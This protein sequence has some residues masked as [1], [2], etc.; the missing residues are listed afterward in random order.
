MQGAVFRAVFHLWV[1]NYFNS[2]SSS[3]LCDWL[4]KIYVRHLRSQ[5]H[6]KPSPYLTR[7]PAA[8][9]LRVSIGSILYVICDIPQVS[10]VFL[11]LPWLHGSS[12]VSYLF[13]FYRYR[14]SNVANESVKS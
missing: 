10:A 12:I 13:C 8:A 1:V 11:S 6:T 3:K 4:K 9:L 7:L 14:G 2:F 5:S